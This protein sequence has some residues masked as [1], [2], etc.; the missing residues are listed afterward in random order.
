M[1]TNY[2]HE[3]TLQKQINKSPKLSQNL[4]R[5]ARDQPQKSDVT[6]MLPIKLLIILRL[7]EIFHKTCSCFPT[8]SHALVTGV[9]MHKQGKSIKVTSAQAQMEISGSAPPT[10]S[11]AQSKVSEKGSTSVLGFYFFTGKSVSNFF[12]INILY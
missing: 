3:E 2:K 6:T 10:L 12:E 1:H 9:A 4:K 11:V 5:K 8:I 7:P